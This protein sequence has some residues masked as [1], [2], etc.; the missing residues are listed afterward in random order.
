LTATTSFAPN[1]AGTAQDEFLV[2]KMVPGFRTPRRPDAAPDEQTLREAERMARA[3]T[4]PASE[5]LD[6]ASPAFAPALRDMFFATFNPYRPAV[7][8]WPKL[9]PEEQGRITALPIWDIAVQTEGRARL[10]MACYAATLTDPAMREA[11]ALNAWEENRHKDVLRRLVEAYDIKLVEEPPYT[12]PSDAEWSY[13]VTGFSECVD[14]FFAFG[15]F[16]TARRSGLFPPELVE[17]F[18]PV[19]QEECRHI[20][21]FA[22]WLAWR[23]ARLG[24]LARLR[25]EF[26]V[27]RVWIFLGME[28]VGIARSLDGDKTKDD[29]NFAMTGAS[30]VSSD[31]FDLRSLLALC[32]SENARRFSGYDPR[33][34]RPQT[35]PWLAGVALKLLGQPKA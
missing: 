22:N 10:Y 32:L 19:M 12:V 24:P 6:P 13:L 25:F 20:L 9:S 14:S 35:A 17:T 27:F 29:S 30:S 5:S 2:E 7:I 18:E 34:L 8:A 15:L 23:R 31:P 16:E 4:A 33:L 11:M 1:F 26:K 3:W 28:R 21:L